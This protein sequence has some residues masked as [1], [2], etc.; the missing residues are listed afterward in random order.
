LIPEFLGRFPVISSTTELNIN[1]LVEI[2]QVP[3]NSL[4]KQYR[5]QFSLYGVEIVFSD[6]ICQYVART[7]LQRGSGARGLRSV[8][9]SILRPSIFRVPSIVFEYKKNNHLSQKEYFYQLIVDIHSVKN[10]HRTVLLRR[11]KILNTENNVAT[12][13]DIVEFEIICASNIINSAK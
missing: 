12:L 5:Y 7:A 9:E 2:L 10:A 6:E 8:I 11:E 4:L 3:K 13:S 1:Q